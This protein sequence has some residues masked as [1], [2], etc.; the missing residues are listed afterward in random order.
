MCARRSKPVGPLGLYTLGLHREG[1]TT[2]AIH[3]APHKVASNN[4][5][6]GTGTISYLK[7]PS[8]VF[9]SM[10]ATTA[11]A[12]CFKIESYMAKDCQ[13]KLSIHQLTG[14]RAYRTRLLAFPS[15]NCTSVLFEK[16]NTITKAYV[17]PMA[18][19]FPLA[20]STR[21]EIMEIYY[22]RI[23]SSS[24]KHTQ[25]R[26]H[27]GRSSISPFLTEKPLE[28]NST[29]ICLSPETVEAL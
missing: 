20:E 14:T 7:L 4:S 6:N 1:T 15:L 9:S 29:D 13:R 10:Q 23:H 3:C 22:Q 19:F 24:S 11:A 27:A 28:A 12:K 18:A 16:D 8:I 25:D 2:H 17:N 21:K 5:F 26:E